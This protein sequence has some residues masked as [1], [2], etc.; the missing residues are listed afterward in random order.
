MARHTILLPDD[1][2]D[3]LEQM[4]AVNRGESF[5]HL[6]R[7]AVEKLR[8]DPS[9]FLPKSP[10]QSRDSMPDEAEPQQESRP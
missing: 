7:L 4:L 5:S 3:W 8:L 10:P 1:Q 6:I 2:S 9:L